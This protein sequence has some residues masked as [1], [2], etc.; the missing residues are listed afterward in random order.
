MV[1]TLR[2]DIVTQERQ[3][4]SVTDAHMII[5]PGVEGQLGI[6]PRHA[7]LLTALAEGIMQVRRAESEDTFA[8]HGGFMEV[9]PDRVTVLADV[10]ERA[11]EIDLARAEEARQRA[12][13]LMNKAYEGPDYEKAEA[14]MRR[15][16]TR[17]KVARRKREGHRGAS[18]E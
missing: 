1:N 18:H 14:A 15:S 8:I 7:P 3:I 17:L 2:C 5:A 13:E 11:E 9:L 16:L 6:L 4:Y 12:V 10:A